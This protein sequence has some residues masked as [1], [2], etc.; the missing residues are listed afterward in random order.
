[1]TGDPLILLPAVD[2][3]GGQAVRLVTGAPLPTLADA[4]VPTGD[5]DGQLAEVAIHRPVPSAA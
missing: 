1:M 5:T 4:V 2:V 3:A